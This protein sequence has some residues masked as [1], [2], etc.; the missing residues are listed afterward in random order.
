MSFLCF[1]ILSLSL[2]HLALARRRLFVWLAMCRTKANVVGQSGRRSSRLTVS[3][4]IFFFMFFP[5]E[6]F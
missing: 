1:H 2:H 4:N 3:H 5:A 6:R